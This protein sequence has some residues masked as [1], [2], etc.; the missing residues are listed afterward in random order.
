MRLQTCLYRLASN[1]LVLR[2]NPILNHLPCLVVK[3]VN[4]IYV[5]AVSHFSTGHKK[6]I[7]LSLAIG[8]SKA[9]NDKTVIYRDGCRCLDPLIT[10]RAILTRVNTSSHRLCSF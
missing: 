10:E 8:E 2:D 3:W 9:L 7:A 5:C 6:K 4:S 1:F